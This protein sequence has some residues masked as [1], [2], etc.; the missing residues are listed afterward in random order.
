[1]A[2]KAA[3]LQRGECHAENF[4][5]YYTTLPADDRERESERV[6]VEVEESDAHCMHI[7]ALAK[8]VFGHCFAVNGPRPIVSYNPAWPILVAA[9]A[10]LSSSRGLCLDNFKLQVQLFRHHIGKSCQQLADIECQWGRLE[11]Y[12]MVRIMRVIGTAI[13]PP[14]VLRSPS[15]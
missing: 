12:V 15:I 4:F 10:R 6:S 3:Q 7:F 14:S 9:A 13:A 5:F 1:M 2:T 8:K 11:H